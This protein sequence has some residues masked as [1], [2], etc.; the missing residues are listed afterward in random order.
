VSIEIVAPRPPAQPLDLE[1]IPVRVLP[2]FRRPRIPQFWVQAQLPWAVRG[3]LVSFCNL[4]PVLVLRQI[5]CMHDAQTWIARDSYSWGF[6]LVHHLVLPILGHSSRAVTT[7]SRFSRDHLINLQVVRDDKLVVTYNGH[8]HALRWDP[9]RSDL[10]LQ[11]ERPFVLAIGRKEKHKNNE[12]LQ[13]LAAA[14]E[15]R[16]IDLNVA[17]DIDPAVLAGPGNIL[18][19]NVRL[20][21]RISD[22]DLAKAL[23]SALCF[24]FPSRMEGFGLPA[25]EAMARGCPVILSDTA[26]LPEI[27]GDA[28]LYA[29]PDDDAAWIDGVLRLR[30][31]PALRRAM[32]HKGR[33]RAR[34]YSWRAI[35]EQYLELMARIDSRGAVEAARADRALL[36]AKHADALQPP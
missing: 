21:G 36:S 5:V 9:G 23:D 29:P 33:E 20:L 18:P 35:A 16:G 10:D 13:R 15:R 24:V 27:Y 26:S 7:V 1:S 8:E 30:D 11:P 14:L 22:D 17:G 6:R 4:G 28:A 25:V 2:E 31:D 32:S 12:L 34:A 19:P 3:G